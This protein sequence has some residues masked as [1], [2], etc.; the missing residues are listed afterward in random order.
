[1]K[2]IISSTLCIFPRCGFTRNPSAVSASSVCSCPI[3]AYSPCVSRKYAYTS[4]RL[5]ATTLE[6]TQSL[7]A[8]FRI[9]TGTLDRLTR[10]IA[11]IEPRHAVA[12]G[13]RRA[14]DAQRRLDL[15][16]RRRLTRA[17]ERLA[18][19]QSRLEK[20]SPELRLHRAADRL[21]H[22][23][24]QLQTA[25][26]A[27]V[28]ASTTRLATLQNQLRLVSPQTILDRGF[29]ITTTADGKILRSHSSVTPG[30]LITTQL[31]DGKIKSTVGEPRQ[32]KLF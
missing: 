13:W 3:A 28:A 20:A 32:G 23:A 21:S 14:E 10:G 27:R 17:R 6:L 24:S 9:D 29:S 1:M 25:A 26:A 4:S 2:L 16:T 7:R 8:K 22:T 19:L 18:A 12:Q 30:D 31:A 5:C 11:R 15:A